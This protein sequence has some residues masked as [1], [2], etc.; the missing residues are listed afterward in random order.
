MFKLMTGINLQHVP[1]RGSA[2]AL[3]DLI[4]GQVQVMFDNMP[5][6][7]RAHPCRQAPRAGSDDGDAV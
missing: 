3:T 4:A 7:D 5:V 2:P 1:Y 6:I